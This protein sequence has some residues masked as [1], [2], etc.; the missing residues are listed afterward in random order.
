MFLVSPARAQEVQISPETDVYLNLTQNTRL[1]FQG[2]RAYEEGTPTQSGLGA[3][4]QFHIKPLLKLARFSQGQPD[5]STSR[6]L[7]VG[8]GYRYY[9][10]P[11]S[12]PEN[13]ILLEAAPRV[14]LLWK[15]VVTDRHRGELRFINGSISWRYRNRLMLERQVFV[16]GYGFVPY[17]RSEFYYDSSCHEWSTTTLSIGSNFPIQKHIEFETNYQHQNHTGHVPNHQVEVV[18]LNLNLYF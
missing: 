15:L 10:S 18:G 16:R 8:V 3:S 4:L 7:T 12:W 17:V 6:L 2:G 1:W 5:A 11:K 9:T 13:R 14:P